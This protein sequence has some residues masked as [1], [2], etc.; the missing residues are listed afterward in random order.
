MS[1]FG[2]NLSISIVDIGSNFQTVL[3]VTFTVTE[4]EL[5]VVLM[6]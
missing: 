3:Q 1:A 2:P 4:N 5:Q 6:S